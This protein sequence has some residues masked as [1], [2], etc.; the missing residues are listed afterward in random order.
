MTLSPKR[1]E[2]GSMTKK[3]HVMKLVDEKTGLME[4]L[5]C[6]AKHNAVM[7]PGADGKYLPVNWECVN[8]C[9]LIHHDEKTSKEK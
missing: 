3:E 6:G 7:K 5:V 4:C 8:K 1:I 9:K 2:I